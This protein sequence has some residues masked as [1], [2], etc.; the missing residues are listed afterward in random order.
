MRSL[1]F[2]NTLLVS[3]ACYC[4]DSFML[5]SLVPYLCLTCMLTI[6]NA[7]SKMHSI[8]N[9]LAGGRILIMPCPAYTCRT[10]LLRHT[11]V[12]VLP[13]A[14][15]TF[16]TALLRCTCILFL[17][18]AAYTFRTAFLGVYIFSCPFPAMR[19][20]VLYLCCPS[21]PT[22]PRNRREASRLSHANSAV[23]KL[24]PSPHFKRTCPSRPV[25]R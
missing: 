13:C 16:R 9:V 24:S 6:L 15:Y 12:L 22:M 2:R 7:W 11:H 25:N 21:Q 19:N 10:T 4:I 20:A 5:L 23:P 18:C 3:H 17:P 14:A 8:Y 1:A